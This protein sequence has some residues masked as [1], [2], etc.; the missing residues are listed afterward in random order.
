M[1]Y[2]DLMKPSCFLLAFW[3][4]SL[5]VLPAVSEARHDPGQAWR[6]LATE[7]FLIIYPQAQAQAAARA[8]AWAERIYPQTRQLFGY[9]PPGRTPVVLSAGRDVANGLAQTVY[10]KLELDLTAPEGKS[11]G[12]RDAEWLAV[13]LRHEY[14]HLCHGMRCDGLTAAL[15]AVFGEVNGGNLVAPRWWV[16]GLA[17][18]A[19]TELSPAG[20]RGRSPWRDLELAANLLSTEPWSLGQMDNDPVWA[21][22]A[23]RVYVPGYDLIKQLEADTEEPDLISR[24][25]GR[26]SA[27]P[28]FGLLDTWPAVTGRAAHEVWQEVRDRR[29]AEF[30]QQLGEDRPAMAGARVA[31]EDPKAVFSQPKWTRSQGLV[32]YR[33]SQD[34]DAAL[35]RLDT[36]AVAGRLDLPLHRYDYEPGQDCFVYARLL[37][38]PVYTSTLTADLFQRTVSGEERRLTRGSRAWSPALSADGRVACVVNTFGVT[39]LGLVDRE[40][41]QVD[42]IPG[43]AGAHYAAPAWSPDGRQLAAS[44]RLDGRQDICLVDP[45]TGALSPLTSWDEAGDFDPAWSPDNRYLFFVSDRSGTYQVY[46]WDFDGQALWQV[47]Q[48]WLGAFDPTVSADGRDLAFSEY[49]PGNTQ[50]IVVAPLDP[51]DWKVC[52][53]PPL[54]AQPEAEP[55][56]SLPP[57]DGPGYS[58]WPHLVPTYWMP[59]AGADQDGLLLGAASGRQ[60]PLGLHSWWL[61]AL[62]QPVSQ[63]VYAEASYTNQETPFLLTLRL[64]REP[65]S[66]YGRPGGLDRESCF[67]YRALGAGL[68]ARLPLVLQVAADRFTSLTVDAGAEAVKLASDAPGLFASPQAWTWRGGASFFSGV[69]HDRDPFPLLGLLGSAAYHAAGPNQWFNGRALTWTGEAYFPAGLPGHAWKLGGRG[70]AQSGVLPDAWAGQGPL[71]WGGGDFTSDRVLTLSAA[72]RLPLAHLDDGP[73]LFPFFFHALWLEAVAEQGAGWDGGLTWTQWQERGKA[74]LG[75]A[76]HMDTRWFWYLPGRISAA[77]VYRPQDRGWWGGLSLAVGSLGVA[78]QQV[79]GY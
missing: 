48:A 65:R 35:V 40:R 5:A 43:P 77:A 61:Q 4:L 78:G 13:V 31:A 75:A 72:Y 25:S 67:W 29:T 54:L 52:G 57:A 58:A 27:W 12:P 23:D 17:V 38:D 39:R 21:Y 2:S 24:L 47:T 30:R 9:A 64:F 16:E 71:G 11:F 56:F 49:R 73:G 22:P 60:D 37:M 62:W 66:R 28:L 41:G 3:V 7:H 55:E 44:V 45:F 53:L 10:R 14:A 69:Q 50:R 68:Q 19:E 70:L 42:L 6:E 32:A 15:A 18:Y 1:V 79:R 20:G 33:R 36:M 8:A 59:M 34:Q 74:S 63:E 51:G 76:V 46:A 26:Q